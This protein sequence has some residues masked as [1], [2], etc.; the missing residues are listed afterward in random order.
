MKINEWAYL[1]QP[2]FRQCTRIQG[3]DVAPPLPDIA[4]LMASRIITYF[5]IVNK[6][7]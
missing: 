2:A 7:P 4:T 3:F 6:S 5:K 1:Q